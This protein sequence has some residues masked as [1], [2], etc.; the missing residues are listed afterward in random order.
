MNGKAGKMDHSD[1]ARPVLAYTRLRPE[2]THFR[3]RL[4]M[5]PY[6]GQDGLFLL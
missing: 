4:A 1:N 3:Y 2:G 5:I 6:C